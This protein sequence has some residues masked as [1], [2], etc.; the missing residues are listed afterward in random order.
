MSAVSECGAILEYED[1]EDAVCIREAGHTGFHEA[2][3]FAD[4]WGTYPVTWVNFRELTHIE[5]LAALGVEAAEQEVM[6]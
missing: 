5:K 3:P 1:A 2:I 4:K 6:W